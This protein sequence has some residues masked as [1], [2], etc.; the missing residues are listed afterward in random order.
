MRKLFLLFICMCFASMARAQTGQI[1]LSVTS[2]PSNITVNQNCQYVVIQENSATPSNAF[3]ITL[4]GQSTGLN[5]PAGTRF[6]FSASG[7]GYVS[8]QTIGTISIVS[9]TVQFVGIE[10][11]NAPTVPSKTAG[12]GSSS[13]TNITSG[14]N[15]NT[16]LVSGSLGPSG[17]GTINSTA[18]DGVT[19]TGTP[20]S[21]QI[22]IASSSSAAAWGTVNAPGGVYVSPNCV[23]ITNCYQIH[24]D[25]QAAWTPTC[26]NTS[27]TIQTGTNDPP[28][29]AG[30]VGKL[31]T[32]TTALTGGG[33]GQTASKLFPTG[34]TI[35]TYVGAHQV[36]ASQAA[37]GT[38]SLVFWGTDDST[39]MTAAWTA[40]VNSCVLVH[41]PG[42]NAQNTQA[43]YIAVN[44]PWMIAKPP[45]NFC[46]NA[47]GADR[48]GPGVVG[49]GAGQSVV[50]NMPYFTDN[51]ATLCTGQSGSQGN[52]SCYGWDYGD[53]ITGGKYLR[54]WST[55][56]LGLS[57]ASGSGVY[58]VTIG[59]Q[60]VVDYFNCLGWNSATSGSYGVQFSGGNI[61]YRSSQSD[62]CGQVGA[63]AQADGGLSFAYTAISGQSYFG[64]NSG[65][66]CF[67]AASG[68]VQF[69]GTLIGPCSTTPYGD[70]KVDSGATVYLTS[71]QYVGLNYNGC[72]LT[73]ASGTAYL[74][75]EWMFESGTSNGG[76]VCNASGTS[77]VY[78][79][80]SKFLN[81]NT[82]GYS[83]Y[84]TSGT[85]NFFD[86]GGNT[87]AGTIGSGF[88]PFGTASITGTAFTT[89][90][91]ALTTGWGSS[92]KASGAG[93][94]QSFNFVITGASGS[95]GPVVTVTF[96]TA[97]LAAPNQCTI[98]QTSGTFGVLTNPAIGSLTST[99]FT[100]TWAGTPA[101][102]TYGFSGYCR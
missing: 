71:D 64:D 74:D 20:T 58:M 52:H 95:S 87:F 37:T 101:A 79:V 40:A 5:Y 92:S 77:N 45:A 86:Q 56:G 51:I 17:G 57:A 29:V 30:D 68:T 42:R 55:W 43:A 28:F 82:S 85:L 14:T 6:V 81:S 47:T 65:G 102:N 36:T 90:S 60:D 94:S 70:V 38:C 49:E 50:V 10:S 3:T 67:E 66:S 54:G 12:N 53:G 41:L 88:K 7:N 96:P 15:P 22:P 16:L 73:L 93:D 27:T 84:L 25:G 13:F 8:G 62:G 24:D 35:A 76:I 61:I 46:T 78:A 69:V 4:P 31:I 83:F 44:G 34:T 23:G 80:N 21:G 11:I 91:F 99:G 33:P 48:A 75:N 32:A 98:T 97:Y 9:S 89:S 59:A 63:I 2:T 72:I 100:I 1:V 18:I 19:V 26:V 39:Q